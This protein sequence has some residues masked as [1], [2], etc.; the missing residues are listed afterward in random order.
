MLRY[1]HALRPHGFTLVELLVVIA[2]IGILVALLL[3]A[4]QAAREA[5]RKLQCQ[6]NLKQLAL[7][8]HNYHDARR[9]FPP[10]V[11]FP[12]NDFPIGAS[13]RYRANWAILI[14]PFIE[15]Q[16][17][18]N[19]FDFKVPISH[20]NNRS[21][22]GIPLPT[23]A[24]PTDVGHDVLYVGTVGGSPNDGDNWARGNYAANAGGVG[25]GGATSADMVAHCGLGGV[26]PDQ[27]PGWRN[28]V[29]KGVMGACA[30]I[31]LKKITDGASKTLL[32]G[33]VRVGLN[34]YDPRGTWAL[35]IPGASAL[36]WTGAQGDDHGPNSCN[37]GSDDL[38]NCS[39]L[40]NTDP[41]IAVL[42]K[43]CMMCAPAYH[44][45][46]TSRSRHVGGVYGAYC[47]GSVHFLSDLIYSST[48]YDPP[49]PWDY[50]ITC[51]DGGYIPSE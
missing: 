44:H 10:S 38:L 21:A 15:E 17:T 48:V 27:A 46:G 4:V 14:L 22:R 16:N 18:Y 50:L 45:Q 33:E 3:P 8:L 2:I 20:L 41:G 34:Q 29:C 40:N 47:D 32:V 13:D 28:P 30:S 24:C 51:C 7:A 9:I 23:L 37:N 26:G 19:K 25:M 11:Q 43:E 6:N 35:G 5:G 39:Y 49:G 42:E 12:K 1:P 36:F 31:S